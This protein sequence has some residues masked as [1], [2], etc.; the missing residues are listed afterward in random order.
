MQIEKFRVY[1]AVPAMDELEYLPKMM[2]CLQKQTLTDF[3]LVVCVNQ[4]DDWWADNEKRSI[5]ESNVRSLEF[6]KNFPATFAVSVIDR[7]S[8]GKGWI[9][10]K[11][12]VGQARREVMEYISAIANDS[13]IIISLDA[14]T[15]INPGYLQ[16]VVDSFENQPKAVALSLPYYHPLTGDEKKDRAILHYEIYMRYYVLNLWRIGNPYAFTAIGSA[17]ALPVKVYRAIG[18]IT[19]HHSGEDFYFIQK[20]R[21]YGPVLT[22]SS[23]KVYPASRYSNR[24]GFGT[25]PAMIKGSR[26]N[27]ESYPIYPSVYFDEI[28]QT[29][30]LFE[31]CFYEDLKTPMDAFLVEKFGDEP[32]WHKLRENSRTKENFV[33]ACTHKIDAFRILQFLKWKHSKSTGTDEAHLFEWFEKYYPKKITD[34]NPNI[35]NFS[36]ETSTVEILNEIRDI[37]VKIEEDYQREA[38]K[39]LAI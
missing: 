34:L 11:R 16:S 12:G 13:D 30:D 7:C 31:P 28:K 10:K 36:L 22:Y 17:M 24:V 21:K 27:W 26:G 2:Y 5:C 38:A 32:I 18:G 15:I 39:L 14:D 25:G 8:P 20:L 9:G 3:G 4:P 33:R 19:P 23:E 37:L 1:V 29:C 35:A 6:L